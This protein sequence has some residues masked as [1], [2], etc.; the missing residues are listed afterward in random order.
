MDQ[1]LIIISFS[2]DSS[3]RFDSF[4]RSR[5]HLVAQ[6]LHDFMSF[7]VCTFARESI[8]WNQPR[9]TLHLGG[10][11]TG[12][13]QSTNN[14]RSPPYLGIP[15]RNFAPLNLTPERL[16]KKPRKNMAETLHAPALDVHA[17]PAPVKES[18]I[19]SPVSEHV[20]RTPV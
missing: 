1:P 17:A 19:S 18:V 4:S 6:F 20:T 10:I 11:H 16:T 7:V 12:H 8:L 15:T 5:D 9:G 3:S 2:V 14:E 13:L